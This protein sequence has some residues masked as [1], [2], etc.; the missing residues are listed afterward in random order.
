MTQTVLGSAVV[1]K[2]AVGIAGVMALLLLGLV[3]V[4]KL[5]FGAL[6]YRALGA[7][8]QPVTDKRV[9]ECIAGVAEGGE[10][11]L[12]IVLHSGILFMI[13]LAMITVMVRG[14]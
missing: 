11:L 12:K 6:F 14:G 8:A 2:N 13:S 1:L 9:S 5:A 3:P 4:V 7:V 10:L